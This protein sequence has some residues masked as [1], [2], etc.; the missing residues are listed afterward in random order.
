[1]GHP[2]V[3]LTSVSL[4]NFKNVRNGEVQLRHVEGHSADILALYGQNGSEKNFSHQCP[5][6]LEELFNREFSFSSSSDVHLVWLL[7]RNHRFWPNC[8]GGF[9]AI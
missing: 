3:R 7:K 5:V 8:D 2:I 9:K 4:T 1:M 6:D